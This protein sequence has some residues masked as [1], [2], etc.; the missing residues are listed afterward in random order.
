[1]INIGWDIMYMRSNQLEHQMDE[2]FPEKFEL[3]AEN[4][5]A[6]QRLLCNSCDV[7]VSCAENEHSAILASPTQHPTP[8]P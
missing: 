1:M 6:Q 3:E 2:A 4:Y 7:Y 5:Q 8:T